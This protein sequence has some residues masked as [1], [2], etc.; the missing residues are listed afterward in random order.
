MKLAENLTATPLLK[1]VRFGPIPEAEARGAVEMMLLGSGSQL[2]PVIEWD[3]KTIGTGTVQ[4]SAVQCSTE[5][6]STAVC[7]EL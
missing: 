4:E 1:S 7:W 2:K 3:G 5:Q 6:T